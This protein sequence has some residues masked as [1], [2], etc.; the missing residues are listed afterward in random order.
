VVTEALAEAEVAAPPQE[1][2]AV[3]VQPE[4][5]AVEQQGP[6]LAS[7]S[8]ETAVEIPDDDVPLPGWD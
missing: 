3:V 6:A 4:T 1:L 2:A 7:T 5:A 8:Q